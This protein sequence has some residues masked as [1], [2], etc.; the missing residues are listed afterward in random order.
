MENI[1][2]VD[3]MENILIEWNE[4]LGSD[5]DVYELYDWETKLNKK[6][7]KDNGMNFNDVYI[8]SSKKS[9]KYKKRLCYVKDKIAVGD[10]S[11][12]MCQL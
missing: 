3:A 5:M 7:D 1:E 12:D 10:F 2:V 11:G 9:P 4:S 8:Y 6:G